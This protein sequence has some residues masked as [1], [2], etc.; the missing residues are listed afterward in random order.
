VLV[1]LADELCATN[2][3]SDATWAALA[4]RW[5]DAELVELVALAGFYR[6]VSGFLNATGVELDPGVPGFPT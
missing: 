5:S 1:A 6:M 3:V 2:N 4:A